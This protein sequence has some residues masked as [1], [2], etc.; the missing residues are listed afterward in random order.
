MRLD[1]AL[2][3][4][5]MRTVSA[6]T[7]PLELARTTIRIT[8]HSLTAAILSISPGSEDVGDV[9]NEEINPVEG[10]GSGN[11]PALRQS[12]T[13]LTRDDLYRSSERGE[14]TVNGSIPT[15]EYLWGSRCKLKDCGNALFYLRLGQ[16]EDS[17]VVISTC[18][19]H[20]LMHSY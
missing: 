16:Q 2:S 3:S 8:D 13:R 1:S 20:Q 5:G 17:V 15:G 9:R 7:L 14:Q 18:A 10:H 19:A 12:T 4:T 6:V 11:A